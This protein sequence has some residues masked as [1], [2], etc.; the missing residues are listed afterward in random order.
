MF[1]TGILVSM[2]VVLLVGMMVASAPGDIYILL[3]LESIFAFVIISVGVTL[4]TNNFKTYFITTNALLSN[5]YYISASDKEKSIQYLK[6][7]GRVIMYTG[8]LITAMS[9]LMMLLTIDDPLTIGPKLAVSLVSL[10][11]S[12]LVN[13]VF[14]LPAIHVLEKR[15]NQEEKRVISEKQVMDKLLELCYKQGIT[16]EDIMDAT[17]IRFKE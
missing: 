13:M 6:L 16:P 9:L 15:Y 8:I 5:K 2:G 11:Y 17:E 12:V 4:S 3:N 1:I 14:I 7:M 10:F